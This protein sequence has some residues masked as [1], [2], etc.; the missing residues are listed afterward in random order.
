MKSLENIHDTSVTG[1]SNVIQRKHRGGITSFS[2]TRTGA[3][4]SGLARHINLDT[5]DSRELN[6][7]VLSDAAVP[8]HPEAHI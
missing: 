8:D 2:L 1:M 7:S 5:I 6:G 4:V 3:R